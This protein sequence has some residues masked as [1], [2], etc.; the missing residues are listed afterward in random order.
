MVMGRGL[1]ISPTVVFLSFLFWMFILGGPGALI[2]MPLTLGI[3]L[4]MR[5]FEETRNLVAAVIVI[6][7]PA[8]KPV[9]EATKA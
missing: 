9:K 8:G 3:V 6:H 2:A 7:E 5:N 1:S 4:F